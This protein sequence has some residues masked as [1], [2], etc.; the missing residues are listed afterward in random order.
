MFVANW[1]P[2]HTA[3]MN[4]NV[5]V[6]DGHDVEI[7]RKY[8]HQDHLEWSC[9]LDPDSGMSYPTGW[10]ELPDPKKGYL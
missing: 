8:N 10:M 1:R 6:T 2:I 7:A 9:S 4:K 5:L 3:P